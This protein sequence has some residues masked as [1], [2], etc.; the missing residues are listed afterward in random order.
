MTP[1][2]FIGRVVMVVSRRA[3]AYQYQTQTPSFIGSLLPGRCDASGKTRDTRRAVNG[4]LTV[5]ET[6]APIRSDPQPPPL[7][8]VIRADD[9]G[10]GWP[11]LNG[12]RPVH[13]SRIG[14]RR[15]SPIRAPIVVSSTSLTSRRR[16]ATVQVVAALSVLAA[17]ASTGLVGYII[18]HTR[19][20][21][22]EAAG[23]GSVPTAAAMHPSVTTVAPNPTQLDP[24]PNY[25]PVYQNQG[26]VLHPTACGSIYLDLDD[27]RIGRDSTSGDLEIRAGCDTGPPT[28]QVRSGASARAVAGDPTPSHCAELIL[29]SPLGDQEKIPLTEPFILCVATSRQQAASKGITQ[30]ICV[31]RLREIAPD[32]TVNLLFS[33]WSAPR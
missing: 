23:N 7:K 33:A 5:T 25:T 4:G 17:V 9:V 24:R 6:M 30:K 21:V 22:G 15:L 13:T 16:L 29:T 27:L 18:G 31:I 28:L 1:E 20:A 19:G 3:P 10:T 8:T 32:Q 11:R 12:H 14:S 2:S 26:F